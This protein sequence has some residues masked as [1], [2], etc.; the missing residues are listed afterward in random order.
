[1]ILIH[2]GMQIFHSKVF[3]FFVWLFLFDYYRPWQD[4]GA[5]E[6]VNVVSVNTIQITAVQL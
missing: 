2:S 5:L 1:M 3:F 6:K 4:H